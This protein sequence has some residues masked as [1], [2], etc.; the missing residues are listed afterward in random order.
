MSLRN[1]V[2]IE[3]NDNVPATFTPYIGKAS[4]YYDKSKKPGYLL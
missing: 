3:D 4:T 1:A 2:Y